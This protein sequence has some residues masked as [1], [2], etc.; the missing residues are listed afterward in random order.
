M[1]CVRLSVEKS[2]WRLVGKK[3]TQNCK[4]SMSAKGTEKKGQTKWM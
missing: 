1:R 4:G 2:C 3:L